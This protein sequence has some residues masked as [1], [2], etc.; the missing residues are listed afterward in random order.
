MLRDENN[1]PTDV[2]K[3]DYTA[4]QF[5]RKEK[6][7]IPLVEM[8]KFGG[9]NDK[10][11]FT[12]MARAKGT[13][14]K[15][16]APTLTREQMSD[17]LEDLREHIKQWRQITRPQMQRVDGSALRDVYIGNCTGFGCVKTGHNEEEWL[18]N[19]TPAMRKGMLWPIWK[20][21]RGWNASPTTMNSWVVE[22][23]KKIAQLKAD[24]PRGGPYVLTHGDLHDENIFVSDDN[25]E[26]KFKISAIIDWELAGFFPWW[27]ERYRS[28]LPSNAWPILGDDT[29]IFHPGYRKKDLNDI[30]KPIMAVKDCWFEGGYH[31]WSKHG[32]GHANRWYRQ[33]F[34]AC[35]PYAQE[36]RDSCLGFEQEHMDVFDIDSSDSEDEEADSEDENYKKF[37]KRERQFMRWFMEM[38]KHD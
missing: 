3:T 13:T 27:V 4:Q 9:P 17:V 34:C 35:A 20:R 38:S 37:N 18:E 30:E 8:H 26:K 31:G 36:Y 23:D 22:V 1:N 12:I 33:P 11:H 2:W 5:L 6:P 7:S 29:D 14:L 32:L 16:I 15:E 28:G 21:K 25:P 10:F 24:F 19:L